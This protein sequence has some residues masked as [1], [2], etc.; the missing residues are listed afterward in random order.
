MKNR[1]SSFVVH[2]GGY[3]AVELLLV[4]SLSAVIMGTFVVSLGTLSNSRPST[5]STVINPL[6]STRRANYYYGSKETVNR[7]AVIAPHYGMMAQAEELR[8]QFQTDIVSATAIFC[9]YRLGLNDYRPHTISIN[10]TIHGELDTS[11]KFRKHLVD[12]LKVVLP[13]QYVDYRNPQ[14][15]LATQPAEN[16]TVFM[17]TFSKVEQL[18]KVLSIYEIDVLRLTSTNQQQGFHASV[19]RFADN[20]V[21]ATMPTGTSGGGSSA[22]GSFIPMVF[23]GGY[24]VFYP[25]SVPRPDPSKTTEWAK[26][27]FAPIFISFERSTRL[28]LVESIAI[29]RFKLAAERPFY[30]IWWPDPGAKNLAQPASSNTLDVSD[31][32]QAYN[33]MGGRTSF[34][35]TVPMF[36]AL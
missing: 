9:L 7:D 20:P 21:L 35:F 23:S 28:A 31:P 14:N 17:L 12:D 2:G 10:P 19:R 29:D 1:C 6:D 8:E 34:L 5:T 36:P 30:F 32:R 18:F 22:A 15:T 4:L 33:H 13:T 16:A 27:G 24:E 26:D 11:Q 25:P 3:T